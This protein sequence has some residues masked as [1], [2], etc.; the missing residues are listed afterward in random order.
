MRLF[1]KLA[2]NVLEVVNMLCLLGIKEFCIFYSVHY[3]PRN[4]LKKLIEM[5]VVVN[6]SLQVTQ[7]RLTW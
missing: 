2:P 7:E 3:T 1:Y 6:R 5:S 4:G